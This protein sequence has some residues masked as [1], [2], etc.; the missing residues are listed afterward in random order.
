MSARR[1]RPPALGLSPYTSLAVE[2]Y[3]HQNWH[4]V[5]Y[6]PMAA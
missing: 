2:T 4:A 1:Q 6:M 3:K 5:A